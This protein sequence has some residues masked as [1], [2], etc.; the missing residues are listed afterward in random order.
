MGTTHIAFI[1][2][3]QLPLEF[4]TIVV[5]D[6]GSLEQYRPG[7][8]VEFR[9]AYGGTAFAARTQSAD[10]RPILH[11]SGEVGPVP[12][13]AESI[14]VRRA[15]HALLRASW[16]LPHS[17]LI[18]R[19]DARIQAVGRMPLPAPLTPGALITAAT[20]MVLDLK[21]Y[22]EL[23]AELLPAARSETGP[24]AANPPSH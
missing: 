17:R 8:P 15:A 19:P 9:F 14:P 6:D 16:S 4:N 5:R 12:Y 11:L 23:L 13:S 1:A 21:P 10:D 3:Q 7:R 24:D 18:A 20:A 22:I 2:K